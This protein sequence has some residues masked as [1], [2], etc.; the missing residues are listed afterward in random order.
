MMDRK[1]VGKLF[2]ILSVMI[3]AAGCA[4]VDRIGTKLDMQAE[5]LKESGQPIYE[6]NLETSK[7]VGGLTSMQFADGKFFEVTNAPAGLVRG[8]VVRIYET[9]KGYEA[10]L[11]RSYE[12]Q[13]PKTSELQTPVSRSGS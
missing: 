1:H 7:R 6:G 5:K 12:S 8:D 13:I 10:H 4:S 11:R 3:G 2:L 9:E